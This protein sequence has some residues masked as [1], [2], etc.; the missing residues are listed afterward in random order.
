M[1]LNYLL[2]KNKKI[3]VYLVSC[4]GVGTS[5]DYLEQSRTNCNDLELRAGTKTQIRTIIELYWVYDIVSLQNITLQIPIV[6][7][8]SVLD[9]GKMSKVWL[10]FIYALNKRAK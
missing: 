7:K 10:C 6:T 2:Q 9:L 3:N 8:S 1:P 4:A 5:G